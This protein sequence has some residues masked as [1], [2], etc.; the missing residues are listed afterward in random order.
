MKNLSTNNRLFKDSSI[1]NN[2]TYNDYMSRFKKLATSIFEWVNLPESCDA[3]WL[4]LCL[5]WFGKASVLYDNN[6][7]FINTQAVPSR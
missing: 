6:F 7:G 1:L 4:E 3:R 5:Y 2:A